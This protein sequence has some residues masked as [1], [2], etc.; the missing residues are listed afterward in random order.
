MFQ[1]RLEGLAMEKHSSLLRPFDSYKEASVVIM[2][3]DP[4]MLKKSL[5]QTD[6]WTNGCMD[7]QTVEQTDIDL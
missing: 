7:K 4:C 1:A 5:P 3:P 2:A 6:R